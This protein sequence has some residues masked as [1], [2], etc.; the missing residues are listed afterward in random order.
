MCLATT[1]LRE[2]RLLQIWQ[3]IEQRADLFVNF[4]RSG[5]PRS[6]FDFDLSALP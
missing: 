1:S 5:F 2:K 3:R 4:V 6:W